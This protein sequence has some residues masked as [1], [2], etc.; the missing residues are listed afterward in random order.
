MQDISQEI[1]RTAFNIE[2]D[3]DIVF[4]VLPTSPARGKPVPEDLHIDM[5]GSIS[6]PWNIQLIEILEKNIRAA[7]AEEKL[8]KRSQAYTYDLAKARIRM[9]KSVWTNVQPKIDAEGKV[10]TPEKLEARLLHSDL[11]S[12][13][14]ARMRERRSSVCSEVIAY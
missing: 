13:K 1:I 8:P 3:S 10:E 4:H 6:S 14:R 12:K 7:A 2:E 5:E 9:L 11:A